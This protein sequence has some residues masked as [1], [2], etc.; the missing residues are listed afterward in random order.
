MAYA[1]TIPE[2]VE[3][4]PML[5]LSMNPDGRT[6][7]ITIT[8]GDTAVRLM[9]ASSTGQH[10]PLV[11]LTTDSQILALDSVYVTEFSIGDQSVAHVTF[12]ADAVRVV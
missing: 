9:H 4:E 10:L 2:I 8:A 1:L 5:S 7:G 11:V 12:Q 3:S 6:F